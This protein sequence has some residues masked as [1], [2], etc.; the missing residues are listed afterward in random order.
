MSQF[1]A[2]LMPK[3]NE[4]HTYMFLKLAFVIILIEKN[5][6]FIKLSDGK[7]AFIRYKIYEN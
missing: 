1:K 2:S 6:L 5:E 3:E 4:L 7:S